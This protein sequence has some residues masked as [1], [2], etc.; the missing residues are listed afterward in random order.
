VEQ[1]GEEWNPCDGGGESDA[2][3]RMRHRADFMV[4]LFAGEWRE[5]K[6]QLTE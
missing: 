2:M 1:R 6:V 4:R 5:E 3:A